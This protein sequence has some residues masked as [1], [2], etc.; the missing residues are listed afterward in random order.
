MTTIG[1]PALRHDQ[2]QDAV[3]RIQQLMAE[4]MSSGEA[5]ALVAKEIRENH[6]GEQTFAS[7]DDE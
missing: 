1:S 4:G 6:Q 5:I 2:Q 3:E 7:F